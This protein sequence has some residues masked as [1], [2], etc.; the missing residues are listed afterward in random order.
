M[1]QKFIKYYMDVA[2][3]TSKLS[4]AMRLQVGAVIVRDRTILASGY[5]GMPTG[6][7]NECE[8]KD[9]YPGEGDLDK[10]PL[11]E[12]DKTVESNR[13]YRLVTKDEAL[14]AESNCIS[15]LASS[16]ESCN[17]ATL[18]ITHAPCIHC[19]KLIY[20]SGIKSVYYRDTYR[21][22]SGLDFLEK[23]KVNVTRYLAQ[24]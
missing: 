3:L 17:D 14:H 12:Y 7:D 5:N 24:D 15:K 21:D 16:N 11:V 13:R 6:W 1:K 20:Q 22:T 23:G 19:A 10:Y 18:F 4:S 9:Y 8:Y 2:E